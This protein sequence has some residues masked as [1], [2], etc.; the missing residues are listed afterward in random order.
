MKLIRVPVAKFIN[1]VTGTAVFQSI[2]C[3][4]SVAPQE[5]IHLGH[6]GT[7]ENREAATGVILSDTVEKNVGTIAEHK[8]QVVS[9]ITE[10]DTAINK[11]KC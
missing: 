8:G 7:Q 3:R 5:T 1:V 4:I 10:E 9:E 2:E 11:S 6:V